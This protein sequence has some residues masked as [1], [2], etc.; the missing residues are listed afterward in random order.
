MSYEWYKLPS[1]KKGAGNCRC[2]LMIKTHIQNVH[3]AGRDFSIPHLFWRETSLCKRRKHSFHKKDTILTLLPKLVFQ[4]GEKAQVFGQK[5][6][7]PKVDRVLVSL[8]VGSEP[9][10]RDRAPNA[11]STGPFNPAS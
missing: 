5:F 8:V 9:G 6:P 3:E 10:S 4:W 7:R 1:N 2:M 11:P